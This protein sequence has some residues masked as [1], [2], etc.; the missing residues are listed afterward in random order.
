MLADSPAQT[1][2]IVDGDKLLS[3]GQ[4][5]S[6][7]AN[8]FTEIPEVL[9]LHVGLPLPVTVLRDGQVLTLNLIP[10]PWSGR[11]LLGC[12]LTPVKS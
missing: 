6:T 5:D 10:A 11:G 7:N 1:A 9:R 4:V 3:F 8:P 2:G 12:H